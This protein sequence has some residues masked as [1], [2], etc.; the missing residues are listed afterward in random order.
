MSITE[1]SSLISTRPKARKMNRELI[2]SGTTFPRNKD[3]TAEHYLDRIT[4]LHLQCKK[5]RRIEGLDHS[6]NLQVL[7]LYDNYIETIENISH[8]KTLKC[9]F[10][11]NN[12]ISVI[13]PLQNTNL[14]KLRLD[15]NEIELVS[16]LED[17]SKLQELSV[18][19]Q[20]IPAE[21]QF[22]YRSLQAIARTLRYLDVSRNNITTLAPLSCLENLEHLLCVDNQI[23]ELVDLEPLRSFPYLEELNLKGN[24]VCKVYRYRD[25]LIG[26]S[27][28]SLREVDEQPL[29]GRKIESMRAVAMHRQK[30]EM[31]KSRVKASG[32]ESSLDG[33]LNA[34]RTLEDSNDYMHDSRGGGGG[35]W[36]DLRL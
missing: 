28:N 10:I 13:P 1:D 25:T 33:G 22:D 23:M 5:I 31:L 16:G 2:L 32:D 27:S 29:S 18:A 15:D 21:L 3:E 36:S 24:P 20:R 9:L 35:N 14:E 17:C 11:S 26:F 12:L 8:I 30:V 4:H 19:T 34:K 6:S 7:Y